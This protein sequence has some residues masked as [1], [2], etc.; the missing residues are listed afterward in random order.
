MKKTYNL[1]MADWRDERGRRHRK[2]FKTKQA[3]LRHAQKMRAAA[4][5][6]K[7]RPSAVSKTSR[8]RG[9]RRKPAAVKGP[10]AASPP[11][12]QKSPGRSGPTN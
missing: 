4:A 3:A 5:A 7:V 2:G 10:A 8:R 11:N 6:K 1:W 9:P 12:S